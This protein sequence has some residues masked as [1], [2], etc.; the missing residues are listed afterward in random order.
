MFC[1]VHSGNV[2]LDAP[3]SSACRDSRSS[4]ISLLISRPAVD[5]KSNAYRVFCLPRSAS[6]RLEHQGKASSRLRRR[7]DAIC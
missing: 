1:N 3:L 2:L 6:H 7:C 4:L 5:V